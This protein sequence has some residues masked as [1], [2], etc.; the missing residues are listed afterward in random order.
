MDVLNDAHCWIVMCHCGYSRNCSTEMATNLLVQF[1]KTCLLY[2]IRDEI[3]DVTCLQFV[4]GTD[5]LIDRR[6]DSRSLYRP[7]KSF[8]N[9]KENMDSF[10][11]LLETFLQ[12]SLVV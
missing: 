2:K 7:D 10:I 1:N 9:R 4:K 3:Q 5:S 6:I 12:T 11:N 8:D